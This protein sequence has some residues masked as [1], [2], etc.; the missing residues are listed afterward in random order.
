MRMY[1]LVATADGIHEEGD[2]KTNNDDEI[3]GPGVPSAATRI[4]GNINIIGGGDTEALIRHMRSQL[5][6]ANSV[7]RFL[8]EHVDGMREDRDRYRDRVEELKHLAR[9][10]LDMLE[11]AHRRDWE[12][13]REMRRVQEEERKRAEA[14]E[15]EK[16]EKEKGPRMHRRR[17][18]LRRFIGL[19]RRDG[20]GKGKEVPPVKIHDCHADGCFTHGI[21]VVP[22]ESM[23]DMYG[24][25]KA[26][27]P[28]STDAVE[29]QQPAAAAPEASPRRKRGHVKSYSESH[30]RLSDVSARP[31]LGDELERLVLAMDRNVYALREDINKLVDEVIRHKHNPTYNSLADVPP[32]RG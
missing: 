19:G 17:D 24:A 11:G 10:T 9:L 27:D 8:H 14:E 2:H 25:Y 7:I 31:S 30:A 1:D 32:R 18:S 28:S 12:V 26:Q 29:Q 16:R 4:N 15:K 20:K 13:C 3:T 23:G 21:G 5:S 6:T 22:G